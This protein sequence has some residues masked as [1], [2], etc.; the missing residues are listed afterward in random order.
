VTRT[1]HGDSICSV[2]VLPGECDTT[3][4]LPGEDI[5]SLSPELRFL[6]DVLIGDDRRRLTGDDDKVAGGAF[7]MF[8]ESARGSRED[9]S[10]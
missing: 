6:V 9:D 4:M 7:A 2:T 3:E 10:S 5:V 1:F 8:E